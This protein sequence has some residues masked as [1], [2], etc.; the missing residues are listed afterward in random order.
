MWRSLCLSLVALGWLAV[1]AL[2]DPAPADD[3]ATCRARQDDPKTREDACER[4][5]ADG[6]AAPKDLAVA[7]AV[8]G[9]AL[10]KKRNLDKAIEGTMRSVF[11][12]SRSSV[13]PGSRRN[14]LLQPNGDAPTSRCA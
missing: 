5:I 10:F 14:E 12:R 4:L 13:L 3:V 2:A 9:D 11:A 6:K 7:Y 8:R 1:P